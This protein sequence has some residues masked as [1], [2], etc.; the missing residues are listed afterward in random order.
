MAGS[1]N[2]HTRN[3]VHNHILQSE[4]KT[5]GA[6]SHDRLQVDSDNAEGDG[7]SNDQD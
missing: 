1:Q 5:E 4:T 7:E 6:G 3:E 2:K